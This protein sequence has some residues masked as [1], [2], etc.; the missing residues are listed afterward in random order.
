MTGPLPVIGIAAKFT[1][2]FRRSAYQP[3][4]PVS[5]IYIHDVLV[6]LKH[7][8]NACRNSVFF[9]GYFIGNGFHY[10]IHFFGTLCPA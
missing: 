4:I 1:H 5:F 9:I 7:A 6:P 3:Y 10:I 8:V 2:T